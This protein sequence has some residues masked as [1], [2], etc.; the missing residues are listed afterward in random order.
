MKRQELLNQYNVR[1]DT[2]TSPGK[3]EGEPVFAPHF[4]A[5]GLE[6]FADDDNG[7][8]FK[9]NLVRDDFEGEFGAEL[10]RFCGRFCGRKRT[11]LLREDSQ[12]FVH[13]Y[14]P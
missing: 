4:W 10:G 14:L 3:F 13:C 12:G 5:L 6:G 2:I 1:G 7:S 9:F 11:L 8:V